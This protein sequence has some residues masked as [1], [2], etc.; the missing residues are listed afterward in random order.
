MAALAGSVTRVNSSPQHGVLSKVHLAIR[1]P[2]PCRVACSVNSRRRVSQTARSP[3]QFVRRLQS[4]AALDAV[5]A[6]WKRAGQ[7]YG[8][9][10]AGT[11]GLWSTRMGS[12]AGLERT[13][14]GQGVGTAVGVEGHTGLS[15]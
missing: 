14:G 4:P 11:N 8:A 1:T 10:L 6:G 5:S 2:C 9:M 13:W 7:G 12:G 15:L 3:V